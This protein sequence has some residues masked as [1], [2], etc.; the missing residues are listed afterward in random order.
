MKKILSTISILLMISLIILSLILVAMFS[1]VCM[2]VI[3]Y[4]LVYVIS[5][6]LFFIIN[7]I[8]PVN[9]ISLLSII[10][11]PISLIISTLIKNIKKNK[12]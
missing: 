11:I 7:P 6:I 3:V 5:Y 1:F 8:I 12:I 4:G 2:M 10:I 9:Y